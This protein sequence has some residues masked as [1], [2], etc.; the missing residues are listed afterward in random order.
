MF[1]SIAIY[2]QEKSES[3]IVIKKRGLSINHELSKQNKYRNIQ[4]NDEVFTLIDLKKL[5]NYISLKEPNFYVNLKK[6]Q[7]LNEESSKLYINKFEEIDSYVIKNSCPEG[8][9]DCSDEQKC[10]SYLA[11]IYYATL[12]FGKTNMFE[13][14][15]FIPTYNNTPFDDYDDTNKFYFSYE[16]WVLKIQE[17]KVKEELLK[18]VETKNLDSIVA[19]NSLLKEKDNLFRYLRNNK[20]LLK[21]DVKTLEQQE[22]FLKKMQ[23]Q[24]PGRFRNKERIKREKEILIEKIKNK[25]YVQKAKKD[26]LYND[27]DF[28]ICI[29]NLKLSIIDNSYCLYNKYDKNKNILNKWFLNL[30]LKKDNLFE[31][32]YLNKNDIRQTEYLSTSRIEKRKL[33]IEKEKEKAITDYKNNINR[34]ILKVKTTEFVYDDIYRN[35]NRFESQFN[36][37]Q[38]ISELKNKYKN[39]I[40]EELIKKTNGLMNSTNKN[41]WNKALIDTNKFLSQIDNSAELI[42]IQKNI[43]NKISLSKILQKIKIK[44][45]EVDKLFIENKVVKFDKYKKE[46]TKI[47]K[48]KIYSAYKKYIVEIINNLK[49]SKDLEKRNYWEEITFN[50]YDKMTL[51][52]KKETNTK[53]VEKLCKKA[54]SLNDFIKAMD[55]S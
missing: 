39:T 22:Q 48:K 30:N 8:S 26:G 11:S 54:L 36:N 46:Y 9:V 7:T 20:K 14:L 24:Y 5:E 4:N 10:N 25:N 34:Q 1:F 33:E 2:G 28:K 43:E 18:I 38:E 21:E 50:L 55:L 29:N 31:Y 13:N 27:L 35:Y 40:K 6:F 17:Y 51:Y 15:I 45:N 23:K 52:S 3:F 44:D 37:N 41:D 47:K 42:L 19:L 53:N 32:T 16:Y 49:T 12:K